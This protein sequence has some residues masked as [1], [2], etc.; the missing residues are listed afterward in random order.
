MKRRIRLSE[1][2]LHSVIQE[3]VKRVLRESTKEITP[4]MELKLRKL[5]GE[6]GAQVKNIWKKCSMYERGMNNYLADLVQNEPWVDKLL[7]VAQDMEEYSEALNKTP[8]Y[9]PYEGEPYN[10]GY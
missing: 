10:F 1:P 2:D 8:N 3:S 5:V 9:G 6:L 7:D 4:E